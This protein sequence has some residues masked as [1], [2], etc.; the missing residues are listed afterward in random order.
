M[1][2]DFMYIKVREIPY[3]GTNIRSTLYFVSSSLEE[4]IRTGMD[5]KLIPII[6]HVTEK[7]KL[8]DKVFIALWRRDQP[9]ILWM[10]LINTKGGTYELTTEHLFMLGLNDFSE[11]KDKEVESE[12]D[13]VSFL[14]KIDLYILF[15]LYEYYWN[16]YESGILLHIDVDESRVTF[17]AEDILDNYHK[18][19]R[20]GIFDDLLI[21]SDSNALEFPS[22][23][24]NKLVSLFSNFCLLGRL[25]NNDVLI[26][27]I[28]ADANKK[29]WYDPKDSINVL[30]AQQVDNRKMIGRQIQLLND[31]YLKN[32]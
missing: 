21:T 11:Y 5:N 20:Q 2:K 22:E 9:K 7:Y 17:S 32:Y 24:G 26:R 25:C 23:T 28:I 19:V 14:K 15:H 29:P 3:V 8:S 31:L 1:E 18:F 16:F 12:A 4:E 30:T 6:E 27:R 10:H 13:I